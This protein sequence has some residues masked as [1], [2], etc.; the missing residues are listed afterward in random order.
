MSLAEYF[1]TIPA[2]P[3]DKPELITY[4]KRPDVVGPDPARVGKFKPTKIVRGPDVAVVSDFAKDPGSLLDLPG[5][6]TDDMDALKKLVARSPAEEPEPQFQPGPMLKDLSFDRPINSLADFL[7]AANQQRQEEKDALFREALLK[8]GLTPEEVRSAEVAERVARVKASREAARMPIP[9][10]IARDRPAVAAAAGAGAPPPPPPPP[11]GGRGAQMFITS[12]R[13]RPPAGSSAPAA[14][15][16]S[17]AQQ[18]R[19]PRFPAMRPARPGALDAALAEELGPAF[20]AYNI[21]TELGARV[22]AAAVEA[23]PA[24]AAAAVEERRRSL[25]QMYPEPAGAG[26]IRDAEALSRIRPRDARGKPKAGEVRAVEA[27]ARRAMLEAAR[28][29]GDAMNYLAEAVRQILRER[30]EI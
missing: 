29:G 6:P 30:G 19:P 1:A 5:L 2:K 20:N 15:L 21:G 7:A 24:A 23:A 12:P 13:G 14:P 17:P 3:Q 8:Q 11:G 26:G 10:V 18:G 25:P 22:P 27:D 28:P 4:E 9:A 16:V